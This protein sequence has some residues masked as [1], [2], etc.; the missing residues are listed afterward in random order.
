MV[1]SFT[2]TV[3]LQV[4]LLPAASCTFQLTVVT[5]LLNTTPARLLPV[6]VVAPLKVYTV[7]VTPQLSPEVTLNSEP[8]AVYTQLLVAVERVWLPTQVMVG[9]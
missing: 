1:L 7:E 6:P 5:P 3:K 8:E 4:A 9:F 2:V